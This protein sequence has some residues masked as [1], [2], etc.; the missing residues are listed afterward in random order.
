MD[1]HGPRH[2]SRRRRGFTLIEGLIVLAVIAILATGAVPA[3]GRFL[4]AHRASTTVNDLVQA[5]AV[6]RSEAIKRGRRVYLAPTG[7]HWRDGWA[8][9]IDGND[10]RLFDGTDADELIALRPALSDSITITNPSSATR[11]PFTDVGAPP[12]TYVM[13]DGHG[14]PRRRNG[15]L[16]IGSLVVTV[17]SGGATSVRTLCLSAYG[18]VRIVVD[19][20][21]CS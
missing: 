12:R 7:A 10:N 15:A 4:S 14:Y 18:R 9:F 1:V 20:A 8:I 21:G 17:R 16:N 2:A 11:E 19:R 13:F 5:M 6:A 3:F